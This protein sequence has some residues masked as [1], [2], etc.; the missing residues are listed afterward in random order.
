[1]DEAVASVWRQLARRQRRPVK[2]MTELW[3]F[4]EREHYNAACGE[5]TENDNPC[6]L[7]KKLLEK[8]RETS[9]PSCHAAADHWMQYQSSKQAWAALA[10]GVEAFCH[11]GLT[12]S[13][14]DWA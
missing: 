11:E 1:M 3:V 4:S 9:A 8:L 6:R 14:E 2:I 13:D 12:L 10:A 7:P 5:A